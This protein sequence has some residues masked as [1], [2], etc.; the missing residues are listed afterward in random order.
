[1]LMAHTTSKDFVIYSNYHLQNLRVESIV[2]MAVYRGDRADWVQ[3]AIESVLKQKY[4]DYLLCV[5]IDGPIDSKLRQLLAD[6]DKNQS[7]LML[8]ETEVNRG[9]AACMNAIIDHARD[10][11]P[12]YFFRMDADDICFTS[13]LSNQVKYLKRHPQVDVVGSAIVEI[14]ELGKQVGRRRV[15]KEHS[16]IMRLMPKRCLLNHPTIA[17]RCHVFESGHRYNAKLKNTQDYF[18]WI[19]LAASGYRFAN[20]DKPLLKFRRAKGF[21]KRRG[22]GKSINEFRAR[23]YAMRTLNR[24]SLG[25][26]HYAVSVLLVRLMPPPILKL[27]YQLDRMVLHFWMRNK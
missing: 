25:N 21:F 5:V 15:P 27:I 19:D 7:R 6:L 16:E 3:L 23:F 26:V 9:L 14:D 1:M 20:I 13:R 2:G 24:V 18:F 22:I 12:S 11:Q 17:I 4:Q 10:F 8:I